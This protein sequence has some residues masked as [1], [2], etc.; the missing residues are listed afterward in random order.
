MNKEIIDFIK[1]RESA[2]EWYRKSEDPT[3]FQSEGFSIG[4]ILEYPILVRLKLFPDYNERFVNDYKKKMLNA[5]LHNKKLEKVDLIFMIDA[6]LRIK[7]YL[8]LILEA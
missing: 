1:L 3:L 4:E 5:V 6:N 2:T 7:Q 8:P